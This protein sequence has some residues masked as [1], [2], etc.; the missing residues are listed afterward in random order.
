MERRRHD[1]VRP[2]GMLVEVSCRPC[3]TSVVRGSIVPT[4][5]SSSADHGARTTER[6]A[7]SRQNGGRMSQPRAVRRPQPA[8]RRPAARRLRRPGPRPPAGRAGLQADPPPARPADPG[9]LLPRERHGLDA[10]PAGGGP[11]HGG[12]H[13]RPRGPGRPARRPRRR[14][15][16][17]RGPGPDAGRRPCGCPRPSCGTC[18]R[19]APR[20]G[21]C[22]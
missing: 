6:C 11:D 13:H 15:R 3:G 14:Q 5:G 21:R 1:L 4:S 17:H 8:P 12:R 20:S 18:S 2:V 9:R 7:R 10:R 22:C 16:E 19:R